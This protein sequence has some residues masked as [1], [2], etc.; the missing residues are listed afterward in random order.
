MATELLT[1]E[2]TAAD[3]GAGLH[4]TTPP[5]LAGPL[6]QGTLVQVLRTL[7]LGRRTGVIH[8]SRSS[9]RLTL[10]L[11]DGHVVSGAQGAVGRL[12][13][14]LERC[15]R[16][17]EA[18]LHVALEKAALEGRRLGPVLVEEGLVSRAQVQEALRLQVRD[19]LFA[20][21][22]WGFGAY[23]F[24]ADE[25]P[26]FDEEISLEIPTSALM[27][28][29][30]ECLESPEAVRQA[31][32]SL[33]RVVEAVPGAVHRLEEDKATVR[34][35]DGFVL[36]RADGTMTA[37]EIAETSPLPADA[38]YQS[39]LSLLCFGALRLGAAR[40][41]KSDP[42]ETVQLP[43]P[44]AKAAPTP[45][46]AERRREI[47]TAFDRLPLQSHFDVL[48]L[49]AQAS[50][51]DVKD[52][53]LRMARRFHP[54][55]V[56]DPQL[57]DLTEAAKAI[58]LRLSDAYNVLR[59][60]DSRARYERTMGLASPAPGAPPAPRREEEKAPLP[61]PAAAVAQSRQLFA[62]GRFFEVVE[63]VSAVLPHLGGGL[64]EQ[65]RLLRVKAYLKTPSGTRQAEAELREMADESP[66][67]VEALLVLGGIYKDNGL[68]RRAG[69]A[70]R[71]ALDRQPGH[72]QA[73]A[74]LRTL[75]L[76]DSIGRS[77]FA[78]GRA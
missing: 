63:L 60:P 72:P 52:A 3:E 19:V 28:E 8:L 75:P 55:A 13:D 17:S 59:S 62:D 44:V 54:D 38:V 61:E 36:S 20:A 31:I 5:P 22:F 33:D 35:A 12:G 65:A 6:S 67:S 14:I 71:K 29:I 56:R 48:G 78:L 66:D 49:G 43:R 15:G 70:F 21:V 2:S 4:T 73:S 58:F 64:R 47:T 26:G 25:G 27:L 57:A 37:R 32:G 68:N 30:V 50:P 18:D 10:R 69:A 16:L 11:V 74:A 39:L 34:P 1:R 42:E 51:D 76:G 40:A 53:Y 45:D 7:H 24:E 77:R 46:R 23:R 9:E 41:R